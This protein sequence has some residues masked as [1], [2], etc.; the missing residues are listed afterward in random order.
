MEP[1]SVFYAKTGISFTMEA[2]LTLVLLRPFPMD[3]AA[4]FA[5]LDV[6]HVL[7]LLPVNH[8]L[9]QI[10]STLVYASKLALMELLLLQLFQFNVLLALL[11]VKGVLVLQTLVP[12][13]LLALFF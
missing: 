12:A 7:L 11:I 6:R 2:V 1:A 3:T 9:H 13:V 5:Q 4:Q 10:F 8:V